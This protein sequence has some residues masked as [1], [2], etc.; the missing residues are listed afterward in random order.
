MRLVSRFFGR[1]GSGICARCGGGKR[2]GMTGIRCRECACWGCHFW[3]PEVLQVAGGGCSPGGASGFGDLFRVV[4]MGEAD[5]G[6]E[7][8]TPSLRLGFGSRLVSPG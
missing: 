5:P 8:A 1:F 7:R 4:G 3:V 2:R 6:K